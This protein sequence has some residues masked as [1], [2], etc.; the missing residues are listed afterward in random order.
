MEISSL[1]LHLGRGRFSRRTDAQKIGSRTNRNRKTG[2]A[3]L[4]RPRRATREGHRIQPASGSGHS[5][6]GRSDSSKTHRVLVVYSESGF[7]PGSEGAEGVRC[8]TPSGPHLLPL[9]QHVAVPNSRIVPA[10]RPTVCGQAIIR[11]SD[12]GNGAPITAPRSCSRNTAP[13]VRVVSESFVGPATTVRRPARHGFS[14][15]PPASTQSLKP[16]AL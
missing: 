1:F 14:I 2:T 3:A 12:K 7:R 5:A 4:C 6:R 15:A 9:K 13:S 8:R 16:P 11:L 10:M